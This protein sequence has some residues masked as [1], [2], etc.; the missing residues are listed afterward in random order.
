[1]GY[2]FDLRGRTITEYEYRLTAPITASD[3][4]ALGATAGKRCNGNDSVRILLN[5]E[6]GSVVVTIISED[7]PGAEWT[8]LY[9]Q[10]PQEN[11]PRSEDTNLR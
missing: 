3:L 6:D 11:L 1:M 10:L 2:Q 9:E 4:V 8:P 7:P 5:A